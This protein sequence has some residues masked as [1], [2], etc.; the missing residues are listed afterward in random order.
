MARKKNTAEFYF[1]RGNAY[2]NKVDYDQAIAD[3]TQAISINPNLAAAKE[4]LENA[5]KQRGY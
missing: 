4:G 5:Q 3:Y 2:D 1:N